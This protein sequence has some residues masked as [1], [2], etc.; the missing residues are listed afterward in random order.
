MIDSY[1]IMNRKTKLITNMFIFNICI[2]MILIIWGI[3][4]LEYQSYFHIHSKI[5]SFNSYYLLEVL[6]PAKEVNQVIKENELLIGKKTYNY[7]IYKID[8]TIT[9]QKD[10]NYQKIYLEVSNLEDNYKVNNFRID[11]KIPAYKKKIIEYFIE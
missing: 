5:L 9:Y 11:I 10:I 8:N 7:T 2:I 3:N 4:T 1:I 6:V